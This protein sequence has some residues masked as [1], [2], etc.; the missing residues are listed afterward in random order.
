MNETVIRPS[1]LPAWN[2]CARRVAANELLRGEIEAKGDVTGDFCT[3]GRD[4]ESR[5]G[6]PLVC[7]PRSTSR[8]RSSV[9]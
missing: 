6:G 7:R 4:R 3:S 9:C 8:N 2:D 1:S 5:A